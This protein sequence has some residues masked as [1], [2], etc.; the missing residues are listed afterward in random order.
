MAGFDLCTGWGTPTGSNLIAALVSPPDALLITPCGATAA[1]GAA[2]GPFSPP[3]M[4]Y[5]LTNIGT[6]SLNWTLVNTSVWLS[7]SAGSGTLVPGGPAT[8]VTF[9]PNTAAS[10]LVTGAYSGTVWFTNLNDNVAQNRPVTIAIVTPPAITSQPGNQAVFPGATAVFAVGT[11]GNALLAYR[12]QV[13]NGAYLTN[14]TDGGNIAGSATATLTVSN[15]TAANVGAYSVVVSN[16]LGS[17]VSSNALLTM[18][19]WRPVITA[20]P[21]GQNALPDRP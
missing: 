21:A 13:D 20:Q 14:V 8:N 7:A 16:V 15:V 9:T 17:V 4:A 11:A 10:N 18:L 5:L 12:W 19:P 3:T 1:I 2:G 6:T